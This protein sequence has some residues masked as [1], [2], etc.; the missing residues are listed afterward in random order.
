MNFQV[1]L[2]K[3]QLRVNS[4]MLNLCDGY[5]AF[6]TSAEDDCTNLEVEYPESLSRGLVI[7][8]ALFGGIYVGIPHLIIFIY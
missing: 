8:K 5:P 4:R 7:L 2:M 3:W 6:G 1:G